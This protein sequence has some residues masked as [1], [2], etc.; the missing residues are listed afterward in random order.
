MSAPAWTM[1]LLSLLETEDAR[2]TI[3]ARVAFRSFQAWMNLRE[4]KM[5]IRR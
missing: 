1:E 5:G 4:W 3:A 2:L